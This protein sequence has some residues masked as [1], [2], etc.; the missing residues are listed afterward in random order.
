M[1]TYN[2]KTVWQKSDGETSKILDI[3]S[4]LTY[5]QIPDNIYDPV[6]KYVDT[7]WSGLSFIVNP[8]PIIEHRVKMYEQELAEYV[9]LASF[10]NLA[11]YKVTKQ[12]TLHVLASPVDTESINNNRFLILRDNEIHFRWEEITH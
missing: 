8:K 12:T 4:Y 2:W 5:K 11:E 10:R 7:D 3:I 1:I 9:A 6:M